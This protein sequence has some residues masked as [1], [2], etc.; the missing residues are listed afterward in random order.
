MKNIIFFI[1]I[2]FFIPSVMAQKA[3]MYNQFV[4][5][6]AG[7]NPAASG[8]DINQKFNFTFGLSNQWF[9]VSGS[10]IQN[11]VN[12]SRTYKPPRSYIR[13][14]NIGL[15]VD[16]RTAGLIYN[17]GLYVNYSY[18][19]IIKKGLIASFG[20][21]AGIKNYGIISRADPNDPVFKNSNPS[22][23]PDFIPGFR[24]TGKKFFMDIAIKQINLLK[25]ENFEGQIN[26]SNK[27]RLKYGPLNIGTPYALNP[28][29]YFAY[30]RK[31]GLTDEILFLPSVAVNAEIID[32][33]IID[34]SAMFFYDNRIG[35]GIGL[36]NLN[37]FNATLQLRIQQNLTVGLSYSYPLNSSRYA[38]PNSFEFIIGV[39]PYGMNSKIFGAIKHSVSK[40]PT[41]DY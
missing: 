20:I 37:F 6:K 9:G 33:P 12:I 18:H 29:I 4:F 1:F 15:Y 31:I 39:T 7:L 24:F 23:Y 38:A 30:G 25:V 32:I 40:S 10:P 3:S 41:L 14:H 13:W 2:V 5:N 11:F 35:A 21:Y 19:I 36:K 17:A 28:N 8:T 22:I 26:F 34:A 16:N 27:N